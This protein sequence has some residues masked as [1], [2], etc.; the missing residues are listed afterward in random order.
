MGSK[1]NHPN[2]HAEKVCA[3]GGRGARMTISLVRT[4]CAASR[5]ESML[6]RREAGEDDISLLRTMCATSCGNSVWRRR[7]GGEAH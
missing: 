4:M 7:E 2:T 1:N 5:E 3:G 6:R